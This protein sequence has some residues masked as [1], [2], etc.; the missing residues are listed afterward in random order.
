MLDKITTVSNFKT[1]QVLQTQKYK[2][3]N[4][5]NQLRPPAIRNSTQIIQLTEDLHLCF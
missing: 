3:A 2:M 5:N 4:L 1:L